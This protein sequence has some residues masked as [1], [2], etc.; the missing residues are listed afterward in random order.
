MFFRRRKSRHKQTMTLGSTDPTVDTTLSLDERTGRWRSLEIFADMRPEELLAFEAVLRNVHFPA[1]ATILKE[2]D[3]GDEMYFLDR[4]QVRV[5]VAGKEGQAA[6]TRILDAPTTLGEMALVT[7]EP[8]TATLVAHTECSCLLLTRAT[9]EDL[10]KQHPA[11]A[12][13]LTRL[14]GVRLK[15]IDGIRRVGKYQIVGVLGK[16]AVA[17]VFEAV[18]PGLGQSVALKMLSHALVYDPQFGQQFDHEARLVASL[19]H[20][21]IVR[22]IDFERAYGTRFIVMECLEGELLEKRI[23]G[24]SGRPSWGRIRRIIREIGDALSYAHQRGLIHRD[25]KPSNV[26][27]TTTGPAKLLD[28]GIA[29]NGDR[30]VTTKNGRLGSPC[31]MPPEQILGQPLDARTDLYALGMTAYELIVGRVAFDH[32][33]LRELL[34]MQLYSPTPD[35]RTVVPDVPEDL[36]EFVKVATAKVPDDR[37]A[38]CLDAIYILEDGGASPSLTALRTVVTL[39]HGMIAE[40]E[41]KAAVIALE[42]A[43][44]GVPGVVVTVTDT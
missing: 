32:Q 11:V 36:A 9:F 3:S 16:G 7:Q 15:E 29:V 25:V 40:D 43:L 8:R 35:L 39:D 18:H 44:E 28:F 42:N 10:I 27:L 21:N 13:L 23:Y 1:G 5:S 33:D 41:V 19:D 6:F 22:V 17:D 4:G 37:F 2:A 34:K 24:H 26:F 12:T 14:V 20:P 30:S 38:D 31:Y